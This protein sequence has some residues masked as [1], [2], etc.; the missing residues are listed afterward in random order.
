M[1]LKPNPYKTNGPMSGNMEYLNRRA[2]FKVKLNDSI[3][4][5]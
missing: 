1:L 3:P 2:Y 4:E 5:Y